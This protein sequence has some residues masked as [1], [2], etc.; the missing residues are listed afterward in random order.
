MDIIIG[1]CRE[2][3]E[4]C[5]KL[6]G[7]DYFPFVFPYVSV[8]AP[9]REIDRFLWESKRTRTRFRNRYEGNVVIDITA[10]S[11]QIP[12]EYFEAFM[13]FLE[14]NS[15]ILPTV[16]ISETV[17]GSHVKASLSKHFE[18]SELLLDSAVDRSANRN[19][20]GFIDSEA[21]GENNGI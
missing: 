4:H 2:C 10:W 21:G 9:F 15:D 14:D 6:F 5:D 1:S 11:T 18:I 3:A 12:N 8:D 16:F 20:I 13:C 7:E 19:V 17:C